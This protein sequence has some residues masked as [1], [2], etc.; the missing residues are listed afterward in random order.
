MR[1]PLLRPLLAVEFLV[2]LQAAFTLWSQVGGEYHLSLVFWP[3]KLGIGLAAAALVVVITATLVQQDGVMSRRVLAL[4]SLLAVLMLA[5][6]ALS[7]DAHLNEPADDEQDEE[8]T[9]ATHHARQTGPVYL[10]SPSM[11]GRAGDLEG[12]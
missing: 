4:V 11:P 5:A 9:S 10:T 7:Y 12:A 2:A 1:H 3:W 8:S 6:G